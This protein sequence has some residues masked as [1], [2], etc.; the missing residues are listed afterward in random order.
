MQ[1]QQLAADSESELGVTDAAISA[2]PADEGGRY[3][4]DDVGDG[5]VGISGSAFSSPATSSLI[6]AAVAVLNCNMC[7]TTSKAR[8]QSQFIELSSH[9][10]SET[11]TV[12]LSHFVL[13]Y[14]LLVAVIIIARRRNSAG[15][16]GASTVHTLPM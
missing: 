2:L 15:L 5:D 6:P 8:A 13:L 14:S 10:H 11:S 9:V 12:C 4:D 7:F 1:E 3:S 16:T